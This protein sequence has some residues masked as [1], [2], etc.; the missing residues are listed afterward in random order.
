MKDVA[1]RQDALE[2]HLSEGDSREIQITFAD[3]LEEL[4]E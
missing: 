1:A 4:A 2:A 3:G